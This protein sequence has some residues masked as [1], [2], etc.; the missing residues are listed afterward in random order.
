MQEIIQEVFDWL[1]S[2]GEMLTSEAFRLAVRQVYSKVTIGV[3][4][5]ILLLTLSFVLFKLAKKNMAEGSYSWDDDRVEVP[6][7]FGG[8]ALVIA[9]VVLTLVIPR[10][11]NPEWYA[12]KEI[13]HLIQ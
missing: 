13:L 12:I 5:I 4:W 1:V 6:I 8:V 7:F 11:I 2:T 9:M 10:I 3:V